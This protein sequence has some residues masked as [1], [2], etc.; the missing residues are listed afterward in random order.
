MT[1][2]AD[3]LWHSICPHAHTN[4]LRS[5]LLANIQILLVSD[6]AVHPD[7]TGTCAWVIWAGTKVW[8]GEGYTPGH[9]Q[10]MYSG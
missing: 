7:R 2:W 5:A 4:T 10:D 8:S 9:L 3:L 6:A 1:T